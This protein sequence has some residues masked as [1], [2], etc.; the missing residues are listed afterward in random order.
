MITIT[1]L[2]VLMR[3]RYSWRVAPRRMG[4][5][6][7]IGL[8]GKAKNRTITPNLSNLSK[9]IGRYGTMSL[10]REGVVM[11][12]LLVILLSFSL[13]L[14]AGCG[15]S[16]TDASKEL[17]AEDYVKY[18][19]DA[20]LPIGE[21]LVVSEDNDPNKLLGRP[22]Q[23][24]S[25]I[26]FEDTRVEQ[27][28]EGPVGGTVEVFNN[29]DDMNKRKDYLEGIINSGP[30]IFVQYIY[31]KDNAILRLENDLTPEQAEE[32]GGILQEVN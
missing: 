10:K 9:A 16:A 32:Y 18:F 14:I 4:Q 24:T 20:G 13:L 11:R 2:I 23:Y 21:V 5:L 6:V 15:S 3:W 1:A 17:T 25:K 29:K 31:A 28:G 22:N 30:A 7:G 8:S 26:I 12:K 19:K 27:L